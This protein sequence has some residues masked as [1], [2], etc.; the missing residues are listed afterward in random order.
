MPLKLGDANP[1]VLAW[2]TVMN[3]RFGP[4]YTQDNGALPLNTNVF[5]LRAQAWQKDYQRRT[6]QQ[7]TG[8][9][10]DADLRGLGIAVP[11]TH[12]MLTCRGTGG[13]IG[14]DYT[15][16]LA[17]A[18]PGIYHEVPMNYAASM[19]GLPVGAPSGNA[20][21]D[22]AAEQLHEMLTAWVLNNTGTFGVAGYSLGTKGLIMF[23]NDL[24]DPTHPLFAHRDR[25]VCVVLIADPWRPFG[26]SFFLGPITSGQGIGA[27]YFTMSAAAQAALGW[28]CCWLAQENDMYTN[29][30]LGAVGQVLA[31]VEQIILSTS[32]DDPLGTMGAAAK[33]LLQ[34][35]SKD[36]GLG[37]LLGLPGGT[38]TNEPIGTATPGG[39]GGLL[40][41]LLG[42]G[43]L[44]GSMGGGA[45]LSGVL[46][47]STAL[48]GGIAG[49]LVGLLTGLIGG[50]TGD[51]D[52]LQPGVQADTE[53]A[54]LALKFFGGGI[55][56]HLT[57]EVDPWSANNGQTYLQLGI[58]HAADWGSRVPVLT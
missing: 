40:G 35:V 41:G 39:L 53:A 32:L 23:L 58:Q 33:Y 50:I 16:Q 1:T 49:S 12:A 19:G 10:S 14:L 38:T 5:G 45:L 51:G 34:L 8:I 25:L 31:D 46:G 13:I 21:G 52:N 44:I 6:H 54:I 4:V 30:P 56:G 17:Q 48:T 24:F 42:G 28:R 37:T 57:Y 27:P 3:A 11:P 43:G 2:R 36:G 29:S 20:S 22:K 26:K 18:L 15:S 47:G 7:D 9:V 55:R